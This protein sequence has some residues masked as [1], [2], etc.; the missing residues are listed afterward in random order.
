ML[1][2]EMMRIDGKLV[3]LRIQKNPPSCVVE[4]EPTQ[5]ELSNLF[6]LDPRAVNYTPPREGTYSLIPSGVIAV[7]KVTNAKG[8]TIG[9]ES[10]LE[11]VVVRQGA[12]L[13]IV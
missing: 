12:S 7:S 3:T 13:R 9:Y 10:P 6:I 11:G 1:A 5:E 2:T 8:E 4:R